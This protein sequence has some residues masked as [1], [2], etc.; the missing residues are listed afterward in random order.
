MTRFLLLAGLVALS[1]CS[2]SDPIANESAGANLPDVEKLP[3]DEMTGAGD[4]EGKAARPVDGASG[5]AAQIPAAL[6][7]RWALAPADCEPG[8]PDAKG[9]MTVLP[10][11]LRFYESRAR[12]VKVNDSS[13]DSIGGDF[14]FTGEGQSW[15]RYQSLKLQGNALVRTDTEPVASYTYARCR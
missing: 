5:A 13:S 10:N 7:G 6:H 2:G 14:A 4:P 12:M 9:L 8:R 15:N 3:P 1:A 11:E